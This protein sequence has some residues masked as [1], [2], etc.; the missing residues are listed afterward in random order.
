L[1]LKLKSVLNMPVFCFYTINANDPIVNYFDEPGESPNV[2]YR[3]YKFNI[4]QKVLQDFSVDNFGIINFLNH[5]DLYTRI[6]KSLRAEGCNHFSKTR[7][8]YVDRENKEWRCLENHPAELFY[9]DISFSYQKEGRII[10]QDNKVSFF[11]KKDVKEKIRPVKIGD[12]TK[13]VAKVKI[14]DIRMEIKERH[15]ELDS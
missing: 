9:K 3:T 12:L 7:M 13:I 15:E 2:K 10:V 6:E 14:V 11:D 5:T 1:D 8:Q 4:P